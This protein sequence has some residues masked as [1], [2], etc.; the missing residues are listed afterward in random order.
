MAKQEMTHSQALDKLRPAIL[1]LRKLIEL[2]GVMEHA[3]AHDAELAAKERKLVELDH[4]LDDK[5]AMLEQVDVAVNRAKID[6]EQALAALAQ[7]L[8]DKTQAAEQDHARLVGDLAADLKEAEEVAKNRKH[9]LNNDTL[10]LEARVRD[11]QTTLDQL[12]ALQEEARR[13]LGV[14]L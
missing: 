9:Q 3:L 5:K 14:S 11:L 10:V 8:R 1:I 6:H 7:T 13:A 2:E 12:M 4:L